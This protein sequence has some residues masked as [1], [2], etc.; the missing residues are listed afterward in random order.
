[1]LVPLAEIAPEAVHP[2]L[3]KT[4]KQLLEETPDRSTVRPF[5]RAK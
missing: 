4:A 5:G 1:V 3:K 2:N